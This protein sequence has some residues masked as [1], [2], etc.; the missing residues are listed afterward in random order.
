MCG[1]VL[2][3]LRMCGH[4]AAFA[5]DRD[6]EADES[7]ATAAR[8]ENRTVITRDRSLAG[9]VDDAILLRQHDPEAQLAELAGAGLDVSLP[10]EL[11]RCGRNGQLVSVSEAESTDGYAPDPAEEPV[12][13]CVDCGQCFW[14]GSHWEDVGR[15]LSDE[16]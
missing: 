16:E 15:A 12:W 8:N 2:S 14:N 3:Q 13:R 9:N 7:M 11:V 5:P 1:G 10:E 6:L 4:D